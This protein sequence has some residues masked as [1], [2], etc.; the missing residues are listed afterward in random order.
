MRSDSYTVY[1]IVVES[2]CQTYGLRVMCCDAGGD[3]VDT[4]FDLSV[5]V[6]HVSAATRGVSSLRDTV[7]DHLLDRH[8]SRQGCQQVTVVEEE[9]VLA[10]LEDLSDSELDTIVASVGGVELP[11]DRL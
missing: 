2:T 6:G 8:T 7:E 10:S 5:V 4:P 1:A 3:V 9:M 11:P